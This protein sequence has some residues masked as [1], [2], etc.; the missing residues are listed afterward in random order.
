MLNHR[1]DDS[2]N[3]VKENEI[4]YGIILFEPNIIYLDK[5]SYDRMSRKSEPRRSYI[6]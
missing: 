5:Y 2:M 3:L 1:P 6:K 4:L